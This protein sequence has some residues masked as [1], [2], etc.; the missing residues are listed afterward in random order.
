MSKVAILAG[1]GIGPEVM[2]QAEK[3]LATVAKQFDLEVS[4]TRYDVGGC[5]IDNHGQALPESTIKGC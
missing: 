3:V 2:A 5:A 4:T 1:D